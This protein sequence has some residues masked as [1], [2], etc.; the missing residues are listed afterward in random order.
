MAFDAQGVRER[1]RGLRTGSGGEHDVRSGGR[2]P[3]LR[4]LASPVPMAD[5]DS[6]SRLKAEFLGGD[7]GSKD[8]QLGL[9]PW[10]TNFPSQYSVH[11]V[12]LYWDS[13]RQ[14]ECS[15][16]FAAD[17]KMR[18]LPTDTQGSTIFSEATCTQSVFYLQQVAPG[19]TVPP[20][21]RDR[22]G[23]E[24]PARSRRRRLSSARLPH[25]RRLGSGQLL[26]QIPGGACMPEGCRRTSPSIRSAPKSRRRASWAPPP[27]R[28]PE[29]RPLQTALVFIA[30]S[31][32]YA[33]MAA[34][35]GGGDT[36][37]GAQGGTAVGQTTASSLPRAERPGSGGAGG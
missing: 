9:A 15:F 13:M 16:Q 37:T 21:D 32:V 17:G 12:G 20:P 30:G 35:S 18:C 27:R 5:A 19:C 31:A 28:I 24:P 4:D 11:P 36:S 26:L 8:Y 7:D 33:S 34:C 22:R 6:G 14:E 23:T 10:V 3:T 1:V 25:R 2:A 29:M